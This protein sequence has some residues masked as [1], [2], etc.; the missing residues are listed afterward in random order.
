VSPALVQKQQASII[1]RNMNDRYGFPVHRLP[2]TNKASKQAMDEQTFVFVFYGYGYALHHTTPRSSAHFRPSSP[3]AT[4]SRHAG[5]H[6]EV[7]C[8]LAFEGSGF[9]PHG[10]FLVRLVF[11][12]CGRLGICTLQQQ[13]PPEETQHPDSTYQLESLRCSRV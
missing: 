10:F 7:K 4:D 2:S 8:D 1:M 13:R 5:K 11:G 9:H 3:T 12:P 6:G